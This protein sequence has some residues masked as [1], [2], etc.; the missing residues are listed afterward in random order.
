MGMFSW[1]CKGC[2][3][4]ICQGEFARLNG[5]KQVYGGYGDGDHDEYVAWHQR[6]YGAA[7]KEQKLDDNPS[8]RAK[9]QG[10]GA[11]RLR[12]LEGY[13]YACVLPTSVRRRG[14]HVPMFLPATECR[15][16]VELVDSLRG[17]KNAM[18]YK[19][20]NETLAGLFRDLQKETAAPDKEAAMC[21]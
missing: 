7:T 19:S 6:C 5:R 12:F 9:N 11:A 16:D 21:D 18:C 13:G 17:W 4:E 14:H 20:V 10:M 15:T 2:G 3:E 1:C 8:K